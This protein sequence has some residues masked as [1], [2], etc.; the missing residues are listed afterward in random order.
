MVH[1]VAPGV[2]MSKFSTAPVSTFI[3]CQMLEGVICDTV[4]NP[5]VSVFSYAPFELRFMTP[6]QGLLCRFYV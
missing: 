6:K 3:S 1:H 5:M 4:A 2:N